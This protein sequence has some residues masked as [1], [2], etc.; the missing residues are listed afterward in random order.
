MV[1]INN[2]MIKSGST[3]LLRYTLQMLNAAYPH[4][5]QE[6]LQRLILE[7]AIPGVGWFVDPLDEKILER[8]IEISQTEGPVL[9][10]IHSDTR[11][12][13]TEA[14]KADRIK[15]T[16]THRDPRDMILSAMDHCRRTAHQKVPEFS[17]FTSVSASIG[18]ACW[19]AQMAC[20]WVSS[21]LPLIIRY[22]DLLAAPVEELHRVR[23]YLELAISDNV[24]QTMVEEEAAAI[25]DGRA[26]NF[27]QGPAEIK[28]C[29]RV[30][31]DRITRLGYLVSE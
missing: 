31:G 28:A 25:R 2:S 19:S 9:I 10:K 6:S 29:E 4:N 3:L 5:G 18:P 24:L 26:F 11:P 21:Q 23:S 7:G 15:M 1:I 8:L 16:F 22:H 20:H 13:L 12:F 30:L 14:L 17:E 27:N